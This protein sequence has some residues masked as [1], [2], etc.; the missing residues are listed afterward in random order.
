MIHN[1]SRARSFTLFNYNTI[2]VRKYAKANKLD[3]LMRELEDTRSERI[4]PTLPFYVRLDGAKFGRFVK[5]Q[6]SLR[7]PWDERC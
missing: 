2:F 5:R 1:I 6:P 7:L 4:D 3:V